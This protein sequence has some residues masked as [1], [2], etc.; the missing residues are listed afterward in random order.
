MTTR[1]LWGRVF[2]LIDQARPIRNFGPQDL[3]NTLENLKFALEEI[4]L[5]GEQLTLLPQPETRH[6]LP[7]LQGRAPYLH[8]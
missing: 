5:R 4:Q 6:T 8:G 1:Q 7:H 3:D 2:G